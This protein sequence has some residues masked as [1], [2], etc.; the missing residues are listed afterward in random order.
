M[1][2]IG[3]HIDGPEHPTSH[4]TGFRNRFFDAG[5]LYGTENDWTMLQSESVVATPI[6]VGRQIWRTVDVVHAVNRTPFI[7]VQPSPIAPEGDQVRQRRFSHELGKYKAT[8]PLPRMV[9]LV[10]VSAP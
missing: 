10:I 8:H 1:D 7:A 9:L 5:A 6:C 3:A 4:I 2:V